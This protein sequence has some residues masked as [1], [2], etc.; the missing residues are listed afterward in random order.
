M[1]AYVL[2]REQACGRDI[3]K[4]VLSSA[5]FYTHRNV[6]LSAFKPSAKTIIK[7]TP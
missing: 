2:T 3:F 7:T 6:A 1:H 5:A 4:E